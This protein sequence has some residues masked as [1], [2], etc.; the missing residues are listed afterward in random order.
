ML[1]GGLL[2]PGTLPELGT[3]LASVESFR[4]RMARAGVDVELSNHPTTDH[5]L[6][7]AEQLRA[8]PEAPNPFVLGRPR[9]DRFMAVMSAMLRGRIA[10]AEAAGAPPRPASQCC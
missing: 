8:H 9:T 4:T 10:A 1:W 7:R 2:P 5:S 6:E 3:Y